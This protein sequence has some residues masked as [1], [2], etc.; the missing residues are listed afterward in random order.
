M[1][2]TEV[3]NSEGSPVGNELGVGFDETNSD[4]TWESA[5]LNGE[6]G[7]DNTLEKLPV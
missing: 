4:N 2:G 7:W 1:V 3:G 5:E 6:T